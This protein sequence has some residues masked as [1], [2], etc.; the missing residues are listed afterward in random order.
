MV[1]VVPLSA[2][3][4]PLVEKVVLA[5]HLLRHTRPVAPIDLSDVLDPAVIVAEVVVAAKLLQAAR[6]LLSHLLQITS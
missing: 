5:D 4:L 1:V 6:V 3:T 2:Q